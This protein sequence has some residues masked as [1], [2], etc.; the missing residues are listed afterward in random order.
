MANLKAGDTISC[1]YPN[2]KPR[3]ARGK[4]GWRRWGAP[5]RLEG[6]PQEVHDSAALKRAAAVHDAVN[7]AGSADPKLMGWKSLKL[8]RIALGSAGDRAEAGAEAPLPS[9]PAGGAVLCGV[10]RFGGR[11]AVLRRNYFHDLGTNGGLRWKSSGSTIE[12]NLISRAGNAS[13]TW[14]GKAS[15]GVEV[16]ALQDW[17]E[18]PMAIDDVRVV[19]NRWEGCGLKNNPVTVMPEATNV[20]ETNNTW[21]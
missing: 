17:M 13:S 2:T 18:G 16:S 5:L 14:T 4:D 21:N 1:F 7:A 11:G 12:N 9:L 20:S 19:G 10:D 6:W 8:W 15:T 3:Y